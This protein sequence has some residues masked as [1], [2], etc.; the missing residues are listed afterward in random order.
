MKWFDYLIIIIEL[1]CFAFL[2]W[3]LIDFINM[4]VKY[5]LIKYVWREVLP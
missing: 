2:I 3:F 4:E 1:L 5:H